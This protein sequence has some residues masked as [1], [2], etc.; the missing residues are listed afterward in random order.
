MASFRYY[1][2]GYGGHVYLDD[3]RKEWLKAHNISRERMISEI[4]NRRWTW[5]EDGSCII[6]PRIFR[7]RERLTILIC[8]RHYPHGG[9]HTFHT[10]YVHVFHS[11]VIGVKR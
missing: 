7:G 6:T 9:P 5:R 1:P 11:H 8:F 3:K 2:Y 4:R 10:D